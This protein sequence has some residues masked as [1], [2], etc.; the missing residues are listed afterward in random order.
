MKSLDPL[1]REVLD[2]LAPSRRPPDRWNE[3]LA[4]ADQSARRRD[5]R[6]LARPSLA[7]FIALAAIIVAIVLVWPFGGGP[8]GTLLERA[9]AALGDGPVLHVVVESGW[10]G[11]QVDLASGTR[12]IVHGEDEYWF[13]PARGI[14]TVSRFAG[15][16]QSES[17]YPP[18]RVAYLNKTLSFLATDYRRA[19]TSGSARVIGD[20]EVSGQP[21]HWIRIDTQMLPDVSDGK[22]HEWAHD[23]A[24]SADT[25]KP[26]ATRETR[27]GN[28]G[29][30]GVSRIQSIESLAAGSGDF[31][32]SNSSPNSDEMRYE[33]TGALTTHEARVALGGKLLSPG[34]QVDGLNLARIS[35]DTRRQ[36]YEPTT[37]RWGIT[38]T[39]ITLFYG[40]SSGGGI[41]TPP[42]TGPYL[43]VSE[44]L[45]LD[46]QF[47]RG[48]QNYSPPEGTIL[49]FGEHI[50]VMQSHGIFVALEGSSERLLIAAARALELDATS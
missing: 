46:A 21:V 34:D 42:P 43:Q 20:A 4:A 38:H 1:V 25:L 30:D 9:A 6:T 18:G 5:W 15:V 16:T 8:R 19:L 32:T 49:L 23:V 14:H 48:V 36:G 26:V 35:R 41:G 17:S 31:S 12:E 7:A 47:Q 45:T 40:E 13:D 10:G 50:G 11:T 22:L 2:E 44:S 3:I 28:L 29:P 33:R 39:G 37:N 27:D 24:V